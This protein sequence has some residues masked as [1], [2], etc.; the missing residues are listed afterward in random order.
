MVRSEKTPRTIQA[1]PLGVAPGPGDGVQRELIHHRPGRDRTEGLFRRGS[2]N[3]KRAGGHHD[4]IKGRGQTAQA[5]AHIG[6]IGQIEA[7]TLP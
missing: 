6:V 7:I 4:E 3:F 1:E 2:V 5:R